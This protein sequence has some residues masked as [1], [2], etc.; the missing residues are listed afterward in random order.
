M[1]SDE[2]GRLDFPEKWR[3]APASLDQERAARVEIAARGMTGGARDFAG[4]GDVAAR[5]AWIGD[6]RGAQQRGV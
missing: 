6:R 4:Q 3:F 1:A 2:M 5:R